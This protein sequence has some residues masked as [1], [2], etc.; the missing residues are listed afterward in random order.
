MNALTACPAVIPLASSTILPRNSSEGMRC[1]NLKKFP[2]TFGPLGEIN[3]HSFGKDFE[4]NQP[5]E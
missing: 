3:G 1:I 4:N 2:L 5:P